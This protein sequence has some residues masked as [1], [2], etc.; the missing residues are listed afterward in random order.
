MFAAALLFVAPQVVAAE[1]SD[2]AD[3][4][5][6]VGR[7]L[8]NWRG[9][10]SFKG[11]TATCKTTISTGDQE[12]DGIGCQALEVCLPPLQGRVD[13]SNA[14]GIKPAVR[15]KMVTALNSD[16]AACV[17]ERRD[18]LIADLVDRRFEERQ[19]KTDAE[20]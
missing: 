13:A 19:R 12:I 10:A 16:L 7:R 2:V 3:E 14:K 6:V 18:V 17:R 9:K 20:N 11:S 4:V 5:I 8:K 1:T 15:K